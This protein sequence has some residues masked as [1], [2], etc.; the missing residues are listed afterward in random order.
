MT[1]KMSAEAVCVAIGMSRASLFRAIVA[2]QFPAGVRYG[3][4]VLWDAD[5]V[6]AWLNEQRA[7][8]RDGSATRPLAEIR[9][10]VASR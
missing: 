1:M 6:E 7:E 8:R 2:S 5:V 4:R 3:K 10:N 9:A